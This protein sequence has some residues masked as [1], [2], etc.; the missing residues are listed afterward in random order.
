[1]PIKVEFESIYS[2]CAA[3]LQSRQRSPTSYSHLALIFRKIG[4]RCKVHMHVAH[5][6]IIFISLLL[7][8]LLRNGRWGEG[9]RAVSGNLIA[10]SVRMMCDCVWGEDE[11][12]WHRETNCVL[13]T[14]SHRTI[15]SG[16]EK[17][18]LLV[19][20]SRRAY[21]LHCCTILRLPTTDRIVNS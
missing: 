9:G 17:F 7:L 8:L 5:S 12:F 1:M 3:I 6:I 19:E 21:C 10:N 20:Y 11:V 16:R 13:V 14:V 2:M 18:N 4:M 15:I